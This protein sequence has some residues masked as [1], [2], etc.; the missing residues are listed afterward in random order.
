ML[1]GCQE[2]KIERENTARIFGLS[3]TNF[4]IARYLNEYKNKSKTGQ[5][6][7]WAECLEKMVIEL[8]KENEKYVTHLID[9]KIS[10][11]KHSIEKESPPPVFIKDGIFEEKRR[12]WWRRLRWD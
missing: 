9:S 7:G 10:T 2:M 12:P 4:I 8:D 6:L 5:P 1:H 3:K 11:R